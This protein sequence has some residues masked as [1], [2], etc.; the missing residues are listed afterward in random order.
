MNKA[1]T[2]TAPGAVWIGAMWL[3]FLGITGL[4]LFGAAVQV[5]FLDPRIP[6]SQA[7]E[8]LNWS[9]VGQNFRQEEF[10][11][12]L[13]SAILALCVVSFSRSRKAR[14][15]A[16]AIGFLAPVHGLG[17]VMLWV[18]VVSP[19]IVFN[20]LAGQ[21]DGEFYVESLPQAAAAGLWMLLCAVH[22]G[23]EVMLLR[24]AKTRA[25]EQAT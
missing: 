20:M 16:L 12:I 19:L 3:S 6:L 4:F 15:A 14:F 17:V 1:W 13:A 8:S 22:A 9:H 18:S 21:V 5:D 25:K 7:I 24:A 2:I 10:T 23:R 11:A